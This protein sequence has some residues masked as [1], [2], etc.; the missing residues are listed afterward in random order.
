MRIRPRPRAAAALPR[1][2]VVAPRGARGDADARR[3]GRG[4]LHAA[5]RGA[6]TGTL[7]ALGDKPD[8]EDL[9]QLAILGT[10]RAVRHAR[11][12]DVTRR[13]SDRSGAGAP[14]QRDPRAARRARSVV[15]R[16]HQ[17]PD[18]TFSGETGWTLQRLLVTT[19][20]RGARGSFWSATSEAMARRSRGS[21]WRHRAR[22]SATPVGSTTLHRRG[23]PGF[24][25]GPPAMRAP[26]EKLVVDALVK[27]TGRR[28]HAGHPG[29]RRPRRGSR[30]RWPRPPRWLRLA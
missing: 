27:G 29:A 6:S 26:L 11:T 4:C 24:R 22:S 8:Q 9:R 17:R 15:A 28:S 13:R 7:T 21:R 18:G 30:R 20:G 10:Q 2:A 23:D 12:L 1:R 25:R 3:G 16:D 19:G 5:P 14:G